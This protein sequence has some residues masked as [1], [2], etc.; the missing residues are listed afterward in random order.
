MNIGVIVT[1]MHE[2]EGRSCIDSVFPNYLVDL[3][4]RA[5]FSCFARIEGSFVSHSPL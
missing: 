2:V 4:N 1:A 5:F 3:K